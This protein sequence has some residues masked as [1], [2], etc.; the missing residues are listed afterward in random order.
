[1]TIT[2][3]NIEIICQEGEIS[4][5]GNDLLDAK[6]IHA[7]KGNNY[8]E[9]EEDNEI[10]TAA[11]EEATEV[12]A[13]DKGYD[14]GNVEPS[15]SKSMTKSSS[16]PGAVTV[17]CSSQNGNKRLSFAYQVMENLKNPK[18]IQIGFNED[19]LIVSED[20]PGCENHFNVKASG[21]KG[22]VYSAQLVNEIIGKFGLDFTGITSR[23]FVSAEY[24]TA[25]EF[26]V[27]VIKI[28]E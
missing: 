9:V 8:G 4:N 3:E 1:M 22:T 21:K 2:K 19:S 13:A 24:Y 18:K 14:F 25:G 17:V 16:I 6:E 10:N 20:I 26:P 5:G 7:E 27:V 11:E 23:T 15:K 28:T 12:E